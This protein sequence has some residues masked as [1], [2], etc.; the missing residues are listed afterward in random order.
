[1]VVAFGG[2]EGGNTFANEQT[3][4]VR[5]D[6]LQRGFHFLAV[7]YF[8]TKGLPKNLDR[9]SLSAIKDTIQNISQNLKIPYSKILLV[10]ASRGGEL[11]LNLACRFDFMGVVALVPA[12]ITIPSYNKKKTTSS[13]TFN[14]LEVPYYNINETLVKKEGWSKAIEK[15]L[16]TLEQSHPGVIPIENTKG[17][18][19]LTSDKLDELWPSYKMCEKMTDRLKNRNFEFPFDHISFEDGHDSSS[20]WPGIFKFLDEHINYD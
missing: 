3:K 15:S 16:A 13:W 17:F 2:S 11:V 9:I 4:S 1:M 10:G 7:N 12:N 19:L 6:F 8:G 5:E 20:H 14:D 18:V